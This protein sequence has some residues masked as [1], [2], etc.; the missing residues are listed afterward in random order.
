MH[1]L[2]AVVDGAPVRRD[3][4]GT[5]VPLMVWPKRYGQYTKAITLNYRLADVMVGSLKASEPLAGRII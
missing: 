5:G 3:E 2:N 4:V 1:E